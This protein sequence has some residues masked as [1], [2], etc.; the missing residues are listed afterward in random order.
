[1]QGVLEYVPGNSILHRCNP[2]TKLLLSLSIC[3]ACFMSGNVAVLLG[4][5]AV[6]LAIGYVGGIFEK[7]LTLLRGMAKVCAFLFVLQVIVVRSGEPLF[8]FVT[9]RGLWLAVRISLR[10]MG[11]SIPLA[12]VLAVT[13]MNDLSNALVAVLHLPYK[14]AF[15]LTTSIRFIPVFMEE[16]AGIME[17]QTARGVEFDTKN[18][19]RKMQLIL[20]LCL[21]LMI[22]SVR[23]ADANAVA[24]E[25]RGF[26]LRTR[27]SAY[28]TYP[29]TAMDA[30]VAV[31]SLCALV[32]GF[33]C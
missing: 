12:L 2:V 21:P 15:T 8:F 14:Y 33:V 6:D 13:Q 32:V 19:F 17:A 1:M 22:T 25:A 9:D 18:F 7:A 28:K 29:F 23:K 3:I 26:N 11:A 4:F 20:P 16:L 30:L 10:L 27:T 24:V 31:F 5:L